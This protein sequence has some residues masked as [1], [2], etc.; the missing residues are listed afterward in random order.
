M[1][2]TTLLSHSWRWQSFKIL[3]LFVPLPS[4]VASDTQRNS[5]GVS[6]PYTDCPPH[7]CNIAK[8]LVTTLNGGRGSKSAANMKFWKLVLYWKPPWCC[9]ILE[10]ILRNMPSAFSNFCCGNYTPYSHSVRHFLWFSHVLAVTKHWLLWV[11]GAAGWVCCLLSF[12]PLTW[13]WLQ[14]NLLSIG[15][16]GRLHSCL[17]G[18]RW[19]F[20][21]SGILIFTQAFLAL[22]HSIARGQDRL[23]LCG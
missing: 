17:R 10:I 12:S 21:T 9:P 16:N 15:M 19:E 20:M 22:Q 23:S 14:L 13:H 2:K 7:L 8:G 3:T 5:C 4:P 1:P 6:G 18:V 11:A